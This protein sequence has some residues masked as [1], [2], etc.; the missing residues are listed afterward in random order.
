MKMFC[1]LTGILISCAC[2]AQEGVKGTWVMKTK[3]VVTGPDYENG[4]P[5]QVSFKQEGD[6]LIIESVF[7]ENNAEVNNRQAVLMNGQPATKTGAASGR[8]YVRSIK[9]NA[10]KKGLVFTTVIYVPEN[11]TEVDLTRIETITVSP[12]GKELTL[13]KKSV[14]T[15]AENWESKAVYVR[16]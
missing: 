6:S 7:I 11:P 14:E 10:D 9:W 13:N 8:K 5:T 2:Y 12:D 15:K 16:K 4:I 1:F 3:E